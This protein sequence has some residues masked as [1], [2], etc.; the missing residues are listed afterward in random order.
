MAQGD[1]KP[2]SRAGTDHLA[3]VLPYGRLPALPHAPPLGDKLCCSSTARPASSS[4]PSTRGGP[5]HREHLRGGA[6]LHGRGKL[7]GGSLAAVGLLRD[8]RPCC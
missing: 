5:Q 7:R 4:K 3:Y 8:P 2:F 6:V 1:V